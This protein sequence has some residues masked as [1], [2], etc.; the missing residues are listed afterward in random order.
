MFFSGFK[1]P[2]Y[3]IMNKI[4]GALNNVRGLFD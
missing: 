1:I 3:K 2:Y 4:D